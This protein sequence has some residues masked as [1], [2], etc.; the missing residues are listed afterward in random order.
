PPPFDGRAV[1]ATADVGAQIADTSNDP[2]H[3]WQITYGD[4]LAHQRLVH[5]FINDQGSGGV[6]RCFNCL[7]DI[8]RVI[9]IRTVKWALGETLTPYQGVGLIRVSKAG[10]QQIQLEWEGA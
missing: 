10:S 6:R 1:F 4:N 2:S 5:W 8:G 3:P 7:T 9:F